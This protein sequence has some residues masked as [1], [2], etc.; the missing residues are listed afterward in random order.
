MDWVRKIA[1]SADTQSAQHGC[2]VAPIIFG[3]DAYDISRSYAQFDQC[4]CG[5]QGA[6]SQLVIVKRLGADDSEAIGMLHRNQ[7]KKFVQ[8]SV[9]G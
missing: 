7:I 5:L 4:R 1:S 9:V 6:I 2:D 3:H 8:L